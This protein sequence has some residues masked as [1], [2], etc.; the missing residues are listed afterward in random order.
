MAW[1][2]KAGAHLHPVVAPLTSPVWADAQ[3]PLPQTMLCQSNGFRIFPQNLPYYCKSSRSPFW[4]TKPTGCPVKVFHLL[5]TSTLSSRF[6]LVSNFLCVNANWLWL[7]LIRPRGAGDSTSPCY[8]SASCYWATLPVWGQ[9]GLVG[10]SW[11]P[12]ASLGSTSDSS[13]CRSK[14]R[15]FIFVFSSSPVAAYISQT[16]ANPSSKATLPLQARAS[17]WGEDGREQ[18]HPWQMLGRC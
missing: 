5:T 11:R 13:G 1:T 2:A 15:A 3:V 16:T 6:G 10:V 4:K 9:Q 17:P 14:H 7:M 12:W 8:H 18:N